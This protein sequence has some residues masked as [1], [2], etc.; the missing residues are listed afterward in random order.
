MRKKALLL[1]GLGILIVFGIGIM[2]SILISNNKHVISNVCD[3]ETKIPYQYKQSPPYNETEMCVFP[4]MYLYSNSEIHWEFNSSYTPL[5]LVVMND[6]NYYKYEKLAFHRENGDII[7]HDGQFLPY[8]EYYMVNDIPS[9]SGVGTWKAPY[10]DWWCFTFI[11][12]ELKPIDIIGEY[13]YGC[14]D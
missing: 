9:L 5:I 11:N 6:E 1:L 14:R 3:M 2:T 12:S 7:C 4:S 8:V 10:L 13:G